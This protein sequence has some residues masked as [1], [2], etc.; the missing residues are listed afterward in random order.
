MGFVTWYI[1]R[2]FGSELELLFA[3]QAIS[4]RFCAAAEHDQDFMESIRTHG[5]VSSPTHRYVQQRE[6]FEFFENGHAAI[7]SCCYLA[8]LLGA[9]AE[10]TRFPLASEEDRRAITLGRTASLLVEI[11]PRA[12]LTLRLQ[13]LKEDGGY[14][15][16]K[17]IRN[18]LAHRLA[19][20]RIIGLE[21][22]LPD[23]RVVPAPPT[24]WNGLPNTI[25]LVIDETTTSTRRAWLARTIAELLGASAEFVFE[26]LVGQAAKP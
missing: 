6:L 26:Y 3:L 2:P 9:R 17:A 11:L 16:W 22:N 18:V 15:E 10:P 4:H 7:E 5:D 1:L 14:L 8:Y 25:R 23:G 24:E 21:F 19:P 12:A 20:G 13:S